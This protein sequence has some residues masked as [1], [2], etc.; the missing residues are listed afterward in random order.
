MRI[1]ITW[2]GWWVVL[3]LLWLLFQGEYN[4]IEQIAATSAAAV[5]ATVAV[6]VRRQEPTGFRLETRWI[7]RTWRVPW[8]VVREFGLMTVFLGRTLV[9]AGTPPTGGFRTLPFPTGGARPAERGRRAFA[10]VAITYSPNSYV[11]DM[12][13][14]Q[15]AVVVHTL[16]PVPR[17]Q[18]LL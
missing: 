9:R 5:A 17:G 14:E 13:E 6:L 2:L 7:A 18:E 11:I 10:A 8:Q 3:A 1:L 4:R 12:D 16:T 15:G